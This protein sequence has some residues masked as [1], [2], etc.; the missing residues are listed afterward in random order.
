MDLLE[1]I[2]ENQRKYR[3]EMQL[4]IAVET[5]E[6]RK[7][8]LALVHIICTIGS[9]YSNYEVFRMPNSSICTWIPDLINE[10]SLRLSIV[11]TLEI[12]PHRTV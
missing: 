4:T 3:V 11:S 10:P 7:Q 8:L 9:E 2:K 5:L 1:E 12:S 6:I